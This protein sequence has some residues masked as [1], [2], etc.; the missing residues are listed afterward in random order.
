MDSSVQIACS[1][2]CCY[3]SYSS[4]PQACRCSVCLLLVSAVLLSRIHVEKF[5]ALQSLD[6]SCELPV[7]VLKLAGALHRVMQHNDAELHLVCR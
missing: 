3:G 6:T 2:I 1:G 4:E 5:L 7:Y